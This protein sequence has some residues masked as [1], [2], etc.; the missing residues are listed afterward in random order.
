MSPFEA[1]RAGDGETA[2]VSFWLDEVCFSNRD[3]YEY[4]ADPINT[5]AMPNPFIKVIGV[6]KIMVEMAIMST[7]L[8][9]A[10]MLLS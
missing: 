8:T 5:T 3:T 9:L 10:A 2:D 1:G 6:A 4:L 7:C